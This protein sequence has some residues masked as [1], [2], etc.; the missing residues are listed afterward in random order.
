MLQHI[1]PSSRGTIIQ[2]G[3]SLSPAQI[4]VS[5]KQSM[6]APGGEESATGA[7]RATSAPDSTMLIDHVLPQVPDLVQ[8][9]DDGGAILE[10]G[11]GADHPNPTISQPARPAWPVRASW[12]LK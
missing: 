5:K 4:F 12:L 9:L 8:A 2:A 6:S 7:M 3:R 11:C 10:I 1:S